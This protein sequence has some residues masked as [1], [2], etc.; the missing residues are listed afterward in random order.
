MAALELSFSQGPEINKDIQKHKVFWCLTEIPTLQSHK[1][2]NAQLQ[3]DFYEAGCF[4]IYHCD[5]NSLLVI[6]A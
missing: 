2:R 6:S 1:G 5:S 3:I 4:K